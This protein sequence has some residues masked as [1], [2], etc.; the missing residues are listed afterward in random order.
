MAEHES[1]VT[2]VLKIDIPNPALTVSLVFQRSEDGDSWDTERLAAALTERGLR[3][4]PGETLASFLG[5]AATAEGSLAETIREGSP[6]ELPSPEHV[7][8]S[9][10]LTMP[11]AKEPLKERVLAESPAPQITRE[12]S[13][14]VKKQ[15]EVAK[16]GLLGIGQG[17]TEIVTVTETVT[18]TERVYI[19]P[20]VEECYYV[21]AENR[22]GSFITATPG[23]PGT[24]VFG[25][26]VPPKQLADHRFY[27]A[28]NLTRRGD[29]VIATSD[30]FLRIGRNWADVVPFTEH[31]WAVE[32]SADQAT[33]YLSLT[34]G[35]PAS[36][37]PVARDILDTAI[38]L[39]YPDD[40]LM[41]EDALQKM[42]DGQIESGEEARLPISTS[43]D[44]SF[45]IVVTEDKLQALLNIHKGKGRG[46]HLNLKE[47]G[48][49]I[50]N[51]GLKKLDLKRIGDDIKAFYNSNDFD[52]TGYVLVEGTAPVPGPERS[53]EFALRFE[54]EEATQ[55]HK[56]QINETVPDEQPE[57]LDEF[58]VDAIQK[59]AQVE[60]EQLVANL[61]PESPGTP[62]ADVYGATI[63]A[64]A[65]PAP[66]FRLF[67]AIEQKGVVIATT[68]GGVLDFAE[69]EGT[70]LLR[71]RAHRDAEVEVEISPNRMEAWLS[72]SDGSGTGRRITED[73]VRQELERAG[74]TTGIRDEVVEK[75]VT[76]ARAGTE[77]R[78]VTVAVGEEPINQSENRLELLVDKADG[79]N[80]RIRRD[81][82]ADYRTRNT[83]TTVSSGAELCRILPSQQEAIDGTTVTGEAVPAKTVNGIELELGANLRREEQEDGSV[84]I[85]AETDGEFVYEKNRMEV[86]TTHTVKGDVDMSVGNLKFPGSV[87][88]GGTIRSGFYVVSSGDI[89]VAGGV[90]GALLSSDG[91]I[92]IKQGVK[93][94]GKAVLRSKR[95]VMSPFVELATVLS[96]GDVVLSSALV[97]SRIKSNG[98]IS[99]K[100]DKGRIVGGIIRARN[101]LEVTSVGSPRGIKTTISFGQDYLIADLI[102]KEEKE[103]DKVKSRITQIDLE[104]R[105]AE[106]GGA[107]ERLTQL[108]QEKVKVLKLMEKRG[109]RLFTLRE[110]FEQHFPSKVVVNGDV[111]AGTVFESHGRTVEI[112]RPRKGIV[113]EFDPHTGNIGVSDLNGSEQ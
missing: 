2:G 105:K 103:I 69:D 39:P 102:E 37:R 58:P 72:L 45:D 47:V 94:A 16:K 113:V 50:K 108:R 75:A 56:R 64:P 41:D 71:V 106:K 20:A 48:A 11:E 85:I 31:R 100:G 73:L 29:D 61:D 30:G 42:V 88:I 92:I 70:Y 51:S 59:T 93:G 23:A 4:V 21:T 83:V 33:C 6:P 78:G 10:G 112:K 66:E 95:S 63:A 22:L 49:A 7:S 12:V 67:G 60:A 101:G 84:L 35:H 65:G 13:E 81:G 77:V 89:K 104:M 54:S 44:A 15:K 68:A 5:R 8:W 57:S 55:R 46:R 24:D 18:R 9:E 91:D 74:V 79:K 19:D 34:P 82:S 26:P 109:L 80:V 62:G 107:D 3:D 86:R 52:L 90:E 99:F 98:R 111:H 32:L 40:S 25:K 43:R 36:E 27:L 53:V 96:V 17:K 110:R 76:A 1:A 87:V 97:R 38:Q 28:D 14:K